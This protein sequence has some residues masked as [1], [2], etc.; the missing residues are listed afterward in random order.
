MVNRAATI[1]LGLFTL[2]YFDL[3]Q[4]YLQQL[5]G[6]GNQQ[7][8]DPLMKELLALMKT[9]P[10]KA[11]LKQRHVKKQPDDRPKNS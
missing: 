3:P 8:Q 2:K 7:P 9:L 5:M 11:D 1:K 6:P 4:E 10:T